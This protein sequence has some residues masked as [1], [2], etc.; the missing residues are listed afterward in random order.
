MDEDTRRRIF[1]PFFTTKASGTGLGL[2]SSYGIIQQHG[3]D[4]RVESA[5]SRGTRFIVT[6]PRVAPGN[7]A[8]QKTTRP[9]SSVPA[10]GTVLVVDDEDAVRQTSARLVQSLGYAALEAS[11][12]VEARAHVSAHVG[13]IDILLC[14][15]AMPGEDGRD[16]AAELVALRPELRV[17]FM[18]GYS[19]DMPDIRV[20]GALFLQKPFD[21]EELAERLAAA[22]PKPA[23]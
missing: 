7:D 4:V 12:G 1:E 13:R 17:V 2:A 5:P 11:D 21:R 18:S 14:D 16:L 6:L 9:S 15:I 3:G 20:E 10:Q 22:S 8:Q 19:S 23:H